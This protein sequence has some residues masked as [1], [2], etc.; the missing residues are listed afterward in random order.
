[1]LVDRYSYEGP[2]RIWDAA[3]GEA[4]V[5]LL[6]DDFPHGT[7]AVAWSPDGTRIVTFSVD[8]IGRMWDAETGERLQS[9]AGVYRASVAE[10]S[11]SGDRILFGGTSNI[12]VWDATAL[13]EVI[14]YP[15]VSQEPFASWSPNG[16][17]IAIAY[18]NGDLKVF[19]AWQ[20][21]KELVAYAKEHCVLRELTPEE[22]TQFGL[23]E[24]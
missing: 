18:A 14:A 8:K 5:T 9:V 12:H 21:L 19:P 2:A 4:L 6:P 11:P 22:R 17:A 13:Q 15:S 1:M 23:P 20:S 10:W 3:T 7:S 24:L 16:T